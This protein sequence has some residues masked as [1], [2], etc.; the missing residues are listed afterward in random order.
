MIGGFRSL[1]SAQH[2][3]L[4][5]KAQQLFIPLHNLKPVSPTQVAEALSAHKFRL[6]RAWR[7]FGLI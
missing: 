1:A 3:I 4:A 7:N 6:T 5:V 2:E